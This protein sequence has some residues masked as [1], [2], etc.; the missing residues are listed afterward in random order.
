MMDDNII[1]MN[2]FARRHTA[3][4]P[5]SHFEGD[6]EE[7]V[8]LVSDHFLDQEEGFRDGVVLVN[9]PPIGFCC[10]VIELTPETKLFSVFKPRA[11]GEAPYIHTT[12]RGE[13][14]QAVKVQVVLYHHDVLAEGNEN[15]P[16]K[17]EWEIV[18]INT[19]PTLALPPMPPMTMARNFLG[20]AG[21][22]RG[23]F[24]AEDFAKAIIYWSDK[25]MIHSE[26]T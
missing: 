1:A 9:L 5:Y 7:L 15:G 25:A 2:K 11:E 20:L 26:E 19:S 8:A 14:A 3:D 16:E 10:G 4:S 23:E 17:A 21:G 6:F 13:K 22:T 24:T 18:S 12:A